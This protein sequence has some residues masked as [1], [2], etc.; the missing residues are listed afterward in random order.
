ME[1][2]CK[3]P[4]DIAMFFNGRNRGLS[5]SSVMSRA[6]ADSGESPYTNFGS[7]SKF[8]FTYIESTD[9]K[10]ETVIAN[11]RPEYIPDISCRTEFANKRIYEYEMNKNSLA[12]SVDGTK[13]S[14]PAYTVRITSGNLKGKTPAEVLSED[15]ENGRDQ[16]KTQYI[17]LKGNLEKYPNNQK[18]MDAIAEA[19]NAYDDGKLEKVEGGSVG[20][21]ITILPQEMRPL[22]SHEQKYGKTFIYE[23][24]IKCYPEDNYQY[25]V[26]IEN[27]YAPVEEKAD[28][29]LNVKK[30]EAQ[31]VVKKEF[32][33]VA[34]DW[35]Y[36]IYMMTAHMRQFEMLIA[37][38]QFDDAQRHEK[39]NRENAK[40][41][42][43][44]AAS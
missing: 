19:I 23:M 38:A 3:Y 26:T 6:L 17:W 7:Y 34:K 13:L 16:L 9:A 15:P 12:T 41:D 33:L 11:L 37:R 24:G 25:V 44:R 2:V 20:S 29:T 14:G 27:Y 42:N 1:T 8:R 36:L 30:K 5:V 21:V 32:R 43:A 10:K 28:G 22:R 39:I 35:N 18:Q 40:A 4:T 31:D